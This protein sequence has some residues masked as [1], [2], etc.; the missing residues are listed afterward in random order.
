MRNAEMGGDS[1]QESRRADYVT[2][3]PILF[4]ASFLL[5]LISNSNVLDF[6]KE[7]PATVFLELNTRFHRIALSLKE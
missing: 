4:C 7:V 3:R 5:R 1:V 6:S 2:I